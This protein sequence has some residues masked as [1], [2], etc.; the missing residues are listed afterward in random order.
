M[1]AHTTTRFA[2]MLTALVMTVALNGGML[3]MFDHTAKSNEANS[4]VMSLETVTI[5]GK[6][7]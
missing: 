6:R 3:F 2:G 5:I 4:V 7:A 1:T